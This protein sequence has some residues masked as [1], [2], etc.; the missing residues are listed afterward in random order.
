MVAKVSKF[1]LSDGATNNNIPHCFLGVFLPALQR[2]C[3][4]F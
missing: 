4:T 3:S 2:V 1:V